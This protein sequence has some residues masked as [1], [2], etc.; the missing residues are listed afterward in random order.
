MLSHDSEVD[1][2]PTL[3]L[4]PYTTLFRSYGTLSLSADGSYTYTLNTA[5]V[6][7]LAQGASVT[8]SF[9]YQATDGLASSN[10]ATHRITILLVN[11]PPEAS[12]D[13]SCLSKNTATVS[14][15]V[16]S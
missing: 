13:S 15:N 6:Q 14:G 4:S 16:L 3:R 10:T 8:D 11:D 1:D 9:S 5:G 7:H 12:Y 2:H